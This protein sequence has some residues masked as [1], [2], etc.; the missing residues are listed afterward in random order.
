MRS[1]EGTNHAELLANLFGGGGHGGAS[2]GRVDLEGVELDTK[3]EVRIKNKDD[4]DFR[5]VND[6]KKILEILKRNYRI[7]HNSQ[8]SDVRKEEERSK[9]RIV[10]AESRGQTCQELIVSVVQEIRKEQTEKEKQEK[11]TAQPSV[12]TKNPF[13][14]IADRANKLQKGS[15]NTGSKK[16]KRKK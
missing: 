10:K 1:Q 4:D 8:M 6:P 9:I 14:K 7:N 5:V 16:G 15:S 12:Q 3:L 11:A 13:A 2:G